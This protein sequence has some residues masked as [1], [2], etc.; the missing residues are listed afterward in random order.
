MHICQD[1]VAALAAGV[2]LLGAAWLWIR[3][4]PY[5]IGS[6]RRSSGVTDATGIRTADVAA[7]LVSAAVDR[8]PVRYMDQRITPFATPRQLMGGSPPARW[9]MLAR[10]RWFARLTERVTKEV[11]SQER[12]A[13][14]L[15]CI[16]RRGRDELTADEKK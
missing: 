8:D 6:L 11:A 12:F 10:R 7:R 3:A 2:P 5:R 15:S 13:A 16:A 9:R 1:E 14:A 4:I